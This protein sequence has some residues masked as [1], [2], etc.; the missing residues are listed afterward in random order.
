MGRPGVG[1]WSDGVSNGMVVE[2]YPQRGNVEWGETKSTYLSV[3]RREFEVYTC[4]RSMCENNRNYP[5]G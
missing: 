3:G 5:L 1:V 4:I 2:G